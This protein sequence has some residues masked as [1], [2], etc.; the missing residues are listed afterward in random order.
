MTSASRVT[1]TQDLG[2]TARARLTLGGS[3]SIN[4]G[5]RPT[6]Y[7]VPRASRRTI[8]EAPLRQSYVILH[9]LN[10]EIPKLNQAWR[11]QPFSILPPAIML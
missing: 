8:F 5:S 9:F 1:R 2:Q 10:V 6:R 3:L 11:V 7:Y 4:A